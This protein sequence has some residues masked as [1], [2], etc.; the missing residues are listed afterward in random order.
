MSKINLSFAF[1]NL[2]NHWHAR[3]LREL[4]ISDQCKLLGQTINRINNSI[5]TMPLVAILITTMVYMRNEDYY[6]VFAWGSLY[7]LAHI[8][9]KKEAARFF[10]S[11]GKLDQASLDAW[12]RKTRWI[13]FGHGAGLTLGMYAVKGVSYDV[14]LLLLAA[15]TAIISESA[16]HLTTRIDIFLR[17]FSM[18]WCAITLSIPI[19]FPSTWPYVMLLCVI[20]INTIYR[21]SVIA[22]A[23]YREQISNKQESELLAKKYKSAKEQAE[24]ALQQ[25]NLFLA[26]ASHD[27]RQPAH[28]IN[29][30]A[31]SVEHRNHQT[32]LNPLISDLRHSAHS[33]NLML[34]SLLDL[35]RLEA[36]NNSVVLQPTSLST[37]VTETGKLF[38]GLSRD[39]HLDIKV[40]LPKQEAWVMGDPVLLRQILANLVH[41]SLRYTRKGGVLIGVRKRDTHYLVQ[42]WDTGVGLSGKE[43]EKIFSPYFRSETAWQ[44][45]EAGQGLG[46]SV[47]A[48]CAEQLRANYGVQSR[49]NQGSCFWLELA[50]CSA[51][52]NLRATTDIAEFSPL[53]GCCLVLEDDWHVCRSLKAVLEDWGLTVAIA[54]DGEDVRKILDQGI[55]P[56]LLLCDQRLASGESGFKIMCSVMDRFPQ[57][58]GLILSGEHDSPEL[59][60]AIDDGYLVLQK[61]VDTK[62]LYGALKSI[63]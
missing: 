9:M 15:I 36:K 39:L 57:A 34:N 48:R 35:S 27:L 5:R 51:P 52:K 17:Q 10:S 8:L 21:Y 29:L 22:Y 41:N 61:P 53:S 56:D 25:K 42:V 16:I 54:S 14:R 28:A 46:L 45:D 12:V 11:R 33:L 24:T 18:S 40:H 6:I 62:I 47:V 32:E 7:V 23:F 38:D 19:L 20:F 26:T 43:Q 1:P 60:Q 37:L 13:A 31:S 4:T 2:Y 44:F 55:I 58:R 3:E 59:Q 30:L 50:A 63:R 49:I